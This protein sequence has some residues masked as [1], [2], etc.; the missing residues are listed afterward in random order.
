[1][2]RNCLLAILLFGTLAV[3]AQDPHFSLYQ[4]A[5]LMLNP[6][7]TGLFHSNFQ[8]RLTANHR[9]QWGNFARQ[10][11][12]QTIYAAYDTKICP[13]RNGERWG[14]G[15]TM[16]YDRSG[17]LPFERG[18]LN[19]SVSY[20][21]L[22]DK[23]F[24]G[25]NDL[26][27]AAGG[28]GGAIL[29]QVKEENFRFDEQF[30]GLEYDPGIPGERLDRSRSVMGDVGAGLMLFTAG[31]E[32]TNTSFTLGV[33]AKHLNK[34]EYRFFD[35]NNDVEARLW[36]RTAFHA[37]A[38]IEVKDSKAALAPKAI[39]L[40]QGPYQQLLAGFDWVMDF[41]ERNNPESLFNWMPGAAI[42]LSRGVVP[43]WRADALV[44]SMKANASNLSVALAY[45]ISLSQIRSVT[46]HGA[47]EV[48][49][50]YHFK[51]KM[52]CPTPCPNY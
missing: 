21:L 16:V 24:L 6:A 23:N 46:N 47:L 31:T 10:N 2:K 36:F 30:N 18:Y 37:G 45:D 41:G 43:D 29:Y 33:S 38:T 42:R 49:L 52:K 26:Y 1:M 35:N 13:S 8:H 9:N 50:Q 4:S 11:V 20:T 22:L 48:L 7:T 40:W 34:P 27:M 3:S 39:F 17:S 12:F 14:V 15:G 44:L 32:V 25:D 5:S 51:G 28:E 19:L